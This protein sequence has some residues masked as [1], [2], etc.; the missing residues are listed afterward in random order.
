MRFLFC[1]VLRFLCLEDIY[2]AALTSE[3]P[4]ETV[5]TKGLPFYNI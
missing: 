2:A 1:Y 4:E 3:R 5:P